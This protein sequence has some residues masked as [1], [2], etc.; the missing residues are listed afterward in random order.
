MGSARSKS[1]FHLKI[2]PKRQHRQQFGGGFLA[3]PHSFEGGRCFQP[4]GKAFFTCPGTGAVAKG[5]HR[6]FSEYIEV[7]RVGVRLVGKGFAPLLH[8]GKGALG[9]GEFFAV[10]FGELGVVALG[11]GKAVKADN[12]RDEGH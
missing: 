8:V 4:S 11:I 1:P 9:K 7:A 12:Q 6:T 10:Y 2:L 3:F 5:K